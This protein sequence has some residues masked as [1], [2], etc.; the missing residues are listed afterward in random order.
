MSWSFDNWQFTIYLQGFWYY[1]RKHLNKVCLGPSLEDPKSHIC[2]AAVKN[3]LA[4][5][6]TSYVHLEDKYAFKRYILAKWTSWTLLEVSSVFVSLA[7]TKTSDKPH[8][9]R[10]KREQTRT[11]KKENTIPSPKKCGKT[12]NK[13]KNTTTRTNQA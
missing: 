7:S 4:Q 6:I 3:V 11:E 8:N 13:H 2:H 10:K 1:E 12:D 9:K 5:E